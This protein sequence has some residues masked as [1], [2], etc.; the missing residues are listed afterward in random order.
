[1]SRRVVAW[2]IGI[3]T[4]ALSL[5]W[6][7]AYIDHSEMMLPLGPAEFLFMA[8][9]GFLFVKGK[10]KLIGPV[11]LIGASAGLLYD[12]G[13]VYA[14]ASLAGHEPFPL[15]HLAAWLGAWL[16][17]VAFISVPMLLVLFPEG[18]FRGGRV[19]WAAVFGL[20]AVVTLVGA[21]L[22]WEV[23]T[24]DL[25]ALST[26]SSRDADYPVYGLVGFGF[27]SWYLFFPAVLTLGHKFWRGSRL[28][29]QQIKW[30]LAACLLVPPI[31]FVAG[32]FGLVVEDWLGIAPCLIPVAIGIAVARYRLYDLGRIVSRTVTYALVVAM[33][34][35][36]FALGV[37]VIPNQ[38]MGS[39][40]PPWLVAAATLAAAALFNPLRRRVQ[41]W[42]DR[43][44]N[45]SRY[46]V[47]RVMDSFAASLRDRV[48]S[49]GVVDGWRGVV[50]ET[51]Q[52]SAVGV[53]VRT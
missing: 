17:P 33:L 2:L 39:E 47:E 43:R 8:V 7:I 11:M 34:G 25:V 30:L 16:G 51:M 41:S 9:G 45:R 26:G 19:W 35:A 12:L 28:E 5:G 13:T 40:A 46:D 37:V 1:M 36:V 23:P 10:G 21:V 20:F 3:W 14:S 49:E 42:V 38:M 53:W 29:R 31:G 4:V 32:Q 15:D 18:S 24:A 48:D 6:V 50:T 52:P 44:F 27:F 22:I